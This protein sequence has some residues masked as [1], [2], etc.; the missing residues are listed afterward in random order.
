MVMVIVR[1]RIR[2]RV[3]LSLKVVPTSKNSILKSL[4]KKTMLYNR[5]LHSK[6]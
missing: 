3:F 4:V 5:K 6:W 2:V 1:V